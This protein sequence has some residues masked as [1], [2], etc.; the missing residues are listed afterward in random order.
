MTGKTVWDD[1]TFV[2]QW[3]ATYGLDMARAVVRAGLVYP[4][5]EN[6]LGNMRRKDM[7]DLGCGNGNLMLRFENAAYRSFTGIDGGSEVI[8]TARESVTDIR[9]RFKH[10][11]ITDR[12]PL[13]NESTDAITNIFVIEEIPVSGITPMFGEAARILRKGGD[14]LVFTNHPFNAMYYDHQ[15]CRDGGPN[16]K[17]EGL[18]GYYDTDPST[19]ALSLMNQRDGFP[20]KVDHHHKSLAHIMNASALSGL[21]CAR[22]CEIPAG[23]GTMDAWANHQPKMG[24][25]PQFL[26][27]HLKKL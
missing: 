11:D 1:K 9:T 17:Y 10:A 19:Y 25:R 2:D 21:A 7:V 27:L 13:E 23:V 22:F 6:M 5:V 16:P 18:K 3:N 4:L 15:A 24:D 12:L 8:K 14:M 26:F 20:V